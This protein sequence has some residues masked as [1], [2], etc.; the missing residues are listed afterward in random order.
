VSDEA[1]VREFFYVDIERTR[2]LLAQ[3]DRGVVE[4]VIRRKADTV[5]GEAGGRLLGIGAGG[6]FARE[7]SREESRSMQDLAFVFF[8]ESA[9][10]KGFLLDLPPSV[11]SAEEWRSGRVGESL[12]EGMLVRVEADVQIL[13]PNFFAARLERFPKLAEA[14]L[15][16]SLT[17]KVHV[18]P[19]NS[20][21][22][23][24]IRL[25]K[26]CGAE[27]SLEQYSG[28][29]RSSLHCLQA[30]LQSG[31]FPAAARMGNSALAECS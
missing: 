29:Q 1:V 12:T 30:I 7:S 20:R 2:S 23:C 21:S 19:S 8:E 11:R 18:S 10:D 9:Y 13:D 22:P 26:R 17:D 24:S 5:G 16:L 28:C 27:W 6:S 15:D 25:R 3:I 14:A 4:E 31:F